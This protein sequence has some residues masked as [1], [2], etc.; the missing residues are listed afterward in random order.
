M[1]NVILR[2]EINIL[3]QTNFSR[4]FSYSLSRNTLKNNRFKLNLGSLVSRR[5]TKKE[6]YR[7]LGEILR[8]FTFDLILRQLNYHRKNGITSG[9]PIFKCVCVS[10]K[11][12]INVYFYFRLHYFPT[13]NVQIQLKRI[14]KKKIHDLPVTSND[15]YIN[16]NITK[17]R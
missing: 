2:L 8:D 10:V 13:E 1:A 12:S 14:K 6:F 9:N 15:R 7:R 3:I 4:L 5:A 16:T 17:N 11:K